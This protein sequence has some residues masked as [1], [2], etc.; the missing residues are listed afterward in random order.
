MRATY[1]N[2]IDAFFRFLPVFG[3]KDLLDA[4]PR[5]AADFVTHMGAATG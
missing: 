4:E 5:A 2:G 3:L 1:A